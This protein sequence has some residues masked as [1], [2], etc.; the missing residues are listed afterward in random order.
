MNA[1]DALSWCARAPARGWLIL[2]LTSAGCSWLVN[3]E[4]DAPRCVV[5]GGAED[6]SDPCQEGMHCLAGRCQLCEEHDRCGNNIDDDCNGKIDD[7]ASDGGEIC[8]FQ[9]DNCNGEIDESFDRDNDTF[10]WC[11][12]GQDEH[13]KDCDEIDPNVHP[14]AKEECD[15]I[16]NN[17]DGR[18]D[19]VGANQSLCP[20]DKP[21]CFAGR[22][23]VR[24][25]GTEGSA[26]PCR[27]DEYCFNNV[28]VPTAAACNVTCPE[29][30]RCDLLTGTCTTA[31]RTK[32]KNGAECTV[33]ADCL[34]ELCIDAAAMRMPGRMGRICGKAC[35]NDAGCAADETCFASGTGARSC[36]PRTEVPI[37]E[38]CTANDDEACKRP[39]RCVIA[40][41]T[42]TGNEARAAFS[43]G[44]CRSPDPTAIRDFGGP[45]A[46]NASC[47]SKLCVPDPTSFLGVC[48]APCRVSDDCKDLY[49]PDVGFTWTSPLVGGPPRA[50][51]RVVDLSQLSGLPPDMGDHAAACVMGFEP[52]A[53]KFGETC[54]ANDECADGVCIMSGAGVMSGTSGYCAPTCCDDLHCKGGMGT[55]HP[56]ARC[57]PMAR[58]KHY[59][60]RCSL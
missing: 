11:G 29:G 27:S 52:G 56:T 13:T 44:Q 32:A 20:N 3:P 4:A 35:C 22:C 12:E 19:E 42:A 51:C 28:C 6:G 14:K 54:R 25:C 24:G 40:P 17:C 16:D 58:G 49:V 39:K 50:F 45:C 30:T 47:I 57:I 55:T 48:S 15:G 41:V 23:I 9:D 26:P 38:H 2:A 34:S 43:T 53:K 1:G 10:T 46:S 37:V 59:E 36:L 33:N 18:I 21:D 60:M 31:P 8:N 5:D 7:E